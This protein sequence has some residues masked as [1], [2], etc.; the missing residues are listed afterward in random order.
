MIEL[1]YELLDKD[2]YNF[3]IESMTIKS[4]FLNVNKVNLIILGIC[5]IINAAIFTYIIFG[6]IYI[7]L[8]IYVV[9]IISFLIAYVVSVLFIML[10]QII[11]GGFQI[12]QQFKGNNR[13][14]KTIIN[15]NTIIDEN[16]IGNSTYNWTSVKGVYN[17]KHNLLI[18]VGPIQAIVIPK[19]IFNSKAEIDGIWE[20][21]QECYNN[22]R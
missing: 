10:F 21:I 19:R 15:E 17:K 11:F 18:F 22:S 16:S 7:S 3:N 9:F 5:S 4:A 12:K 2:L 6:G 8:L 20:Y 1:N 14:A 13:N